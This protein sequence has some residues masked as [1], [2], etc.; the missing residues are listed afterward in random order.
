MARLIIENLTLEQAKQFASWYEGQGE[1]DAAE[2]FDVND[3]PSPYVD[4]SHK[5]K[6]MDVSGDTVTIFCK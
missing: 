5:P 3:V 2:W 6:W 1:Q 4:V